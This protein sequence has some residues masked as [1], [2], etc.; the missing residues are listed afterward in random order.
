MRWRWQRLSMFSVACALVA[1]SAVGQGEDPAKPPMAGA[2][3][4][5]TTPSKFLRFVHT[6]KD[7]GKLEVA[8]TRYRNAAGR[9]VELVSAVH[10]ADPGH[11]SELQRQFQSYES[12]LYE[13]V[14]ESTTRPTP[15][16]AKQMN[17]PVSFLQR[18]L[19]TGLDME[20]QLD[21]LD[22][23]PENFV[24]ADLTPSE[25]RRLQRKR[26][27]SLLTIILRSM[28][29]QM[30]K[31]RSA[32]EEAEG[33]QQGEGK[34]GDEDD[35]EEAAVRD[36]PMGDLVK[37]F[38]NRQGRHLL[39]FVFAQQIEDIESMAAGFSGPDGESVIVEGRNRRAIEVLQSELEKGRTNLGIYYGA[40][41]MPDFEERLLKLGFDKVGHRWLVAWDVS[42]RPD[43]GPGRRAEDGRDKKSP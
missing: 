16:T 30:K 15:E 25:F 2:D 20:F 38:R 31:L 35:D 29:H 28:A 19:K 11:Y 21:A 23:T 3:P 36:F 24:H 10:I 42:K 12:L 40:A 33:E 13:L 26:G 27:E 43:P 22:Y 14:G 32:G 6:A 4:A 37:A 8:V 5:R 39:R 9:Q 7:E 18:M 34:A 17:S 41:H 1:A